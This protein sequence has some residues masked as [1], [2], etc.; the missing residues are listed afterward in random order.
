SGELLQTIEGKGR[1]AYVEALGD[2]SF[3][4]TNSDR[5]QPDDLGEIDSEAMKRIQEQRTTGPE[6]TIYDDYFAVLSSSKRLMLVYENTSAVL[7]DARTGQK[8]RALSDVPASVANAV[9]SDNDRRIA[10]PCRDGSA[11]VWDAESGERIAT[12]RGHKGDLNEAAFG[13]GGKILITSGSDRTSRVW[14]VD[15][16][17]QA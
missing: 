8:L 9:F 10:V 11:V 5:Y 7:Y 2:T 17:P 16:R 15:H 13:P 3:L 14:V 12:F 4:S 6:L 1:A